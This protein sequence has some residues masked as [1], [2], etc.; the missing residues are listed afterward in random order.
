[1]Y[2]Y[3]S[4]KDEAQRLFE[5]KL[6]ALIAQDGLDLLVP[7]AR[8]LGGFGFEIEGALFNIDTL[9]FYEALLALQKGALLSEFRTTAE[10]RVVWEIGA[11]WGGFA[12]QFKSLCPQV[13]YIITDFPE[14]FLFSAV[15]LMT[16]FPHARVAFYGEGPAQ[17]LPED[18]QEADF[19]FIPNTCLDAV[20]PGRLDLTINMVSFQE[21]T[22][23]QV[24]MYV[25][26][27][28]NLGCPYLYSLNRDRSPYN[29]QLTSV[30]SIIDKHYWPREVT[31]LPVSYT[32]MVDK[33]TKKVLEKK[34]KKQKEKSDL[35]YTHIIGW[36][37]VKV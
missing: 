11:G 10:R 22:T 13:T 5:E 28:F 29:T 6:Q 9:K 20:A 3:R 12:Y 25:Q 24:E 16:A 35:D 32:K 2:D 30:R 14:L 21:M 4:H 17:G 27:A 8:I 23:Q 1:V 34:T 36:R 33:V 15:Y 19:V 37:R 31:L 26:Q 18:W 7:E